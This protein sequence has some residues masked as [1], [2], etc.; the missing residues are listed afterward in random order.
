MKFADIENIWA[1]DVKLLSNADRGRVYFERSKQ[2]I[3]EALADPN[4]SSYA[5]EGNRFRRSY[6]I[7][8]INCSPS[9]TI[10]NPKIKA[11]L[12]DA[13][14]HLAQRSTS[15]KL[16]DRPTR[17]QTRLGEGRML[18]SELALGMI[19]ST[20][21]KCKING[22]S[23]PDIPTLLWSDGIH[24]ASSDWLRTLVVEHGVKTSSAWE[25]AKLVRPFFRLCRERKRPWQSIDDAFLLI[26][27]EY[28]HRTQKVSV[29]RVNTSLQTIFAFYRWA[30]ET[31]RVRYRVGIYDPDQL[32]DSLQNLTFPISAKRTFSKGR[33][34]RV[35]GS[36]TTPLTLSGQDQGS[37]MRHTPTEDE[38]RE[39]HEI[40]VERVHGERDS[41]MFSW[42][43][44]TGARRGEFL[45]ACKSHMPTLHQLAELIEKDE[46]WVVR[47]TRKGGAIKPVHVPSDLIVRTLDFIEFGRAEIVNQHLRDDVGYKEP[48]EIFLSSS[49]GLVLHPDSVSSIGRR[50][51]REA[52]IQRASIH[53]LRAR[54][55]VRIIETLVD[56]LFDGQIVGSESSWVE[57]LLTKA[58]EMMGQRD[59]RSLRPYL[60]Y[61]LNRRIQTS[62]FTKAANLATRLRQLKLHEGTLARRMGQYQ[63]LQE[64][65]KQMRQGQNSEAASALRK[66]ADELEQKANDSDRAD[67]SGVRADL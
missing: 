9:V 66:I 39:L 51:F 11:L 50:T 33:Y 58:A 14:R 25:Y 65:A 59:P 35:F 46:P 30:E 8:K 22:Q 10:Q 61:V 19:V 54:Y 20:G 26:W 49:T 12:A 2:V 17:F 32:P 1:I 38:I 40:A 57:T 29:D 55:A 24:E 6:L 21:S 27:R 67:L 42:I 52:G 23:W 56:A 16:T 53:R 28:L 13:D 15:A 18:P 3:T 44:E 62:D 41:L 36:W 5:A 45:Q 7:Q 60:T 43:E 48:D 31:K 47:V 4:G 64:V 34:G 37:R 63:G